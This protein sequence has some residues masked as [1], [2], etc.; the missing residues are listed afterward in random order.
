MKKILLFIIALTVATSTVY[1]QNIVE[2][3]LNSISETADSIKKDV[4]DGIATVDTSSLYRTI[5]EDAKSGL[6]GIADALKVGAEHVYIVI[7]KQQV[8]K[9]VTWLIFILLQI[10]LG[11]L[12]YVGG[13]KLFAY[14][15]KGNPLPVFYTIF[16]G[17]TPIVLL[18][19]GLCHLDVI[20][21]GFLNPEFGAME[22]IMEWVNPPANTTCK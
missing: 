4:S 21:T 18:I 15:D 9:A 14:C 12:V 5:Y 10:P 17:G 1:S 16:I 2:K 8:V 20:V 6:K 3:T 13:K 19:I 22:Q 11:V 7:V